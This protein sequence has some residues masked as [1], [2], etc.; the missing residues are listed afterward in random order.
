[1]DQGEKLINL[2]GQ[3]GLKQNVVAR[4]IGYHPVTLSKKA[5]AFCWGCF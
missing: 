3:L 2:I 5:K 1:M 4:N